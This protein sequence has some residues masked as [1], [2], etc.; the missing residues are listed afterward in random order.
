MGKKTE[1]EKW[2]KER[3]FVNGEE[4]FG[5]H[6][7]C[8]DADYVHNGAE[9]GKYHGDWGVELDFHVLLSDKLHNKYVCLQYIIY[10]IYVFSSLFFHK[11]V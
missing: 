6:L 1:P 9:D 4:E 11:Y 10:I 7:I 3:C 2:V 5:A 8:P